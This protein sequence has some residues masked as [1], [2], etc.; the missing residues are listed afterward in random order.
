MIGLGDDRD[1][2]VSNMRIKSGAWDLYD[3]WKISKR[4]EDV[5]YDE[6]KRFFSLM[7]DC[8]DRDL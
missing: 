8:N 2:R 4:L 6:K 7:V 5:V 1:D 3:W